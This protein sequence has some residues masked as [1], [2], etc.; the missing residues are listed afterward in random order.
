MNRLSTLALATLLSI[1]ALLS[2]NSSANAVS[3]DY[4]QFSMMSARSAGQA[5]SSGK[6]A[7][8][9]T[10]TPNGAYSD[11]AWGD[12]AA[13][14][15][16]TYER[17][18]RDGDW[19]RMIGY[20][21]NTGLFMPQIVTRERLGNINCT[22]L[23]DLAVD[24]RQHYVRW[25][26]PTTAYCVLTEGYMVYQGTR[27]DFTHQQVWFPPSAPTCSNAYYTGQR[28]IKQYEVWRDNNG[29]PGGPLTEKQRRDN[30]FALGLGPAFIITD[31]LHGNWRADLRYHWMW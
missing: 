7:T 1:A 18:Q 24:G 10:W 3:Y 28:C 26:T 22:G 29:S 11:I 2:G 20:G 5:W 23:T 8:Q 19:V 9:W 16:A 14:P 27:I 17:F 13:W 12:P 21:D 30:I 25:S 4:G 31:Y 15:P 6:A